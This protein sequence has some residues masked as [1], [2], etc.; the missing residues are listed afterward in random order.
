MNQRQL[1]SVRLEGVFE[2]DKRTELRRYFH[3]SFDLFESLFELLGSDDVFYMQSEPTRH[4]MI[5][6]FGH[7]AVFY[8]NKLLLCGALKEHTNPEFESLFSVGVDEMGWD[9]LNGRFA[10][11]SVQAVRDYRNSVRSC[12]DG[13]IMSLPMSLPITQQDPFWA[14]LMGCEHERIHIETSSV[15]HRQ[16]PLELV[17]KHLEFPLCPFY[18][19]MPE[20]TMVP[21]SARTV[22]LGKGSED[23]G[24]YGWDNEYGTETYEV[25]DFEASLF[26]V[27]NGEFLDFVYGNGYKTERWWDEEGLKYLSLRNATCPPFWIPKEDG[28]YTYRALTQEI[29]MP[30]NWP[31]EVNVLEAQAFCRW[32]SAQE[33][34]YYRLP[35]EAEYYAMLEDCEIES[36]IFDDDIANINLAHYASSVP[37]NT[38][39][40][41]K[42]YDA[43]GNVWQW[44][45]TPIDG[46][47]GFAPHVWYDD[48]STP[49]FDGKH[50]I[51]KGGSWISTG[52]EIVRTSRYAFRRHFIQHAGFRYV[53]GEEATVLSKEHVIEESDVARSCQFHYETGGE[54]LR[55]CADVI[56]K[57]LPHTVRIVELGCGA[58]RLSLELTR[59]FKAITGIDFSARF[60]GVGVQLLEEGV[61]RYRVGRED[62]RVKLADMNLSNARERVSFFQ[63]DLYNLKPHVRGY[64]C[65]IINDV[66][67][68]LDWDQLND[69][70]LDRIENEGYCIII[71]A[72]NT[73]AERFAQCLEEVVTVDLASSP[74]HHIVIGKKR[75]A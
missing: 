54:I 59:Y 69:D 38:F 3:Q 52:N 58:G 8:I 40:H 63:G 39:F 19:D 73:A 60:I 35:S 12:V 33:G 26:L 43:I 67:E 2:E 47:S 66:Q 18:G 72:K 11:P 34:E 44:T 74:R 21:I 16:M 49:T 50:N 9:E 28:T 31:V 61:I 51:L 5:F 48:F 42:V 53:V 56:G 32:K 37:V 62:Y 20:N 30:L 55:E 14:I 64:G 46:F 24:L 27:S 45:Q 36:D 17:R 65:V 75:R 68:S 22:T 10:W 71:K 13:L 7:T 15:L 41:G 6:Y 29:P 25:D 23:H 70:L 57:Y 1:K 4:P